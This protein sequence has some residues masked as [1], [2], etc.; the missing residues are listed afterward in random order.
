[1]VCPGSWRHAGPPGESGARIADIL[2]L[3]R[4]RL[5]AQ[6]FRF[7]CANYGVF[8]FF[9]ALFCLNLGAK[10]ASFA[11]FKEVISFVFKYF[12]ASFPLFLYSPGFVIPGEGRNP[13]PHGCFA[14]K[15]ARQLREVSRK[16]PLRFNPRNWRSNSG[17]LR[18]V[19]AL[20]KT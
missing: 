4:P 6:D 20:Y 14:E 1:M 9:Q 16:P 3:T 18:P 7:V 12:L 2:S 19:L 15:R 11:A 13:A 10:C 8:C 5:T 17:C